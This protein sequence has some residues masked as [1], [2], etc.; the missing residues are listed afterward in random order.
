MEKKKRVATIEGNWDSVVRWGLGS[1]ADGVLL[2][3]SS[4]IDD[5]TDLIHLGARIL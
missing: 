3:V 4:S 2:D 1:K 5:I